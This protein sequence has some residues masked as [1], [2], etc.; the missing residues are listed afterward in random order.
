MN[1][2]NVFDEARRLGSPEERA[3]YL[4]DACADDKDQRR[5]IEALL[6]ADGRTD[7][8]LDE[9]ILADPTE[10]FKTSMKQPGQNIG[11]YK[12]LQQIGE[13]GFGVVYLAEQQEPVRRRV[14]LKVIK[15]GMDSRQVIA[16]FE[17]E[18]QAL[19]LMDHPN[20]A[21]VLDAGMTDSGRPYF[22]M[23]LVKGL[24]ITKFCDDQELS[25]SER[26]ELFVPVC[27]A[28]QHAHQK[29]VIH[30]DIKPSNVLVGV[31]DGQPVPKVIDFGVAKAIQHQLTEKTVFTKYGQVVGTLEYMSP[32]QAEFNQLDIDTRSDV[33][34]LGAVLY[35]L[36]TGSTPLDRSQLQKAAFD[37][38]LRI[39]REEEPLRPS[40]R[41]SSLESLPAI[42][43][44]RKIEPAKLTR[45]VRG[46][47]DWIVMKSL[48]KERS[49]RYPTASALADDIHRHLQGDP[50]TAAAPSTRYR[51]EK[52][53]N[54]HRTALS[55]AAS[56]L[57]LLIVGIAATASLAVM[58]SRLSRSEH[59]QRTLA[60][61]ETKRANTASEQ[62]DYARKEAES[63]AYLASM[64]LAGASWRQGDVARL[65]RILAK[66]EG[67]EKRGLE[68]NYWQGQ[69]HQH[70][71][72]LHPGIGP[73]AGVK[74]ISGGQE[75]AIHDTRRRFFLD[76][77]TGKIRA[78]YGKNW[79]M[80]P[81]G[82]WVMSPTAL[83]DTTTG[84]RSPLPFR[85]PDGESTHL[86]GVF[87]ADGGRF[88]LHSQNE[89]VVW[90]MKSGSRF[91]AE[92][93]STPACF[94]PDGKMIAF[95]T[96]GKDG[97]ITVRRTEDGHVIA[98]LAE[99]TGRFRGFSGDSRLVFQE[100]GEIRLLGV[101][102]S[103]TVDVIRTPGPARGISSSPDGKYIAAILGETILIYDSETH[104]EVSRYRGHQARVNGLAFT[105]DGRQLISVSYDGTVKFWPVEGRNFV[106]VGPSNL[107]PKVPSLAADGSR[108]LVGVGDDRHLID[109]ASRKTLN[110][111][112]NVSA[113]TLSG[114]G[115]RVVYVKNV[116][117]RS[118][119]IF[120]ADDNGT[121][122]REFPYEESI[123]VIVSSTHAERAFILTPTKFC[124]FDTNSGKTILSV[125]V[126]SS[127][128]VFGAGFCLNKD[129]MHVGVE[130][131]IQILSPSTGALI[132]TI[133]CPWNVMQAV[134][135]SELSQNGKQL[136]VAYEYRVP[137]SF[138]YG[139]AI[140]DVATGKRIQTIDG[141]AEGILY[142]SFSPDG[143]R[144]IS[145]SDITG[146]IRL[147]DVEAGFELATIAEELGDSVR[148]M[149]V[150]A[151]GQRI[152]ACGPGGVWVRDIATNNQVALW[153][154]SE[155]TSE[156]ADNDWWGQV[157]AIQDWL[158]L[159][160]I[161][162]PAKSPPQEKVD[163]ELVSG[164]AELRPKAGEVVSIGG[165]D[166]VWQDVAT[167]FWR[168]DFESV[169]ASRRDHVAA[170]AVC[171]VH[172]DQS[173]EDVRLLIGVDNYAKVYLNEE[174]VYETHNYDFVRPGKAEV[175]VN[176]RSGENVL[177]MRV[178]DL[179][180]QWGA[181]VQLRSKDNKPLTGVRTSTQP[182]TPHR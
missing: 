8:L 97:Q 87:S 154:A 175:M 24:P 77:R 98:N 90:D 171:Y 116:D 114:D 142:A 50:V 108:L 156:Q 47:L 69:L 17:A 56:V 169:L 117:G 100:G 132:R 155:K 170:Y 80:S 37:E 164:E 137:R 103:S 144:I 78:L 61:Q 119:Q 63:R 74:V 146:R 123:Q 140:F 27:N 71:R 88:A 79:P 153:Q 7:S 22:V 36:L 68:W 26:L 112:A 134:G 111:F 1:D 46:E 28:I 48:E 84:D 14:A 49:R 66:T 59:A 138:L 33:Y 143:R 52:F 45:F 101:S 126:D 15:P 23:E 31:Y 18:R 167:G 62:A 2:D 91:S 35:E 19:A 5:R 64:A 145:H 30:R 53:V 125:P 81:D 60:E 178:G 110:V 136:V 148:E 182:L 179:T 57:A 76:I 4:D 34:S 82:R 65:K 41:L 147:W 122:I 3:A 181:S 109:I 6:D 128:R 9:P 43:A 11:P 149:T 75:L 38:M 141:L 118:S 113:A 21:K 159:A 44:K 58:Y 94:S 152:V 89:L 83:I 95:G 29:G 173:N 160:P 131:E 135:W 180:D 174:P 107:Y 25:P 105:S 121:T 162:V 32:E 20:I 151:N 129:V 16:R 139:M 161:P 104:Q 99:E 67:S 96:P 92:R 106:P 54:K 165:S 85:I 55:V 176:L 163:M 13:G 157:G 166:F 120:I 124:I 102:D 133:P 10:D 72:E 177:V 73:I 127:Q 12:L 42:S 70:L 158:V 39:I 93:S 115:N 130:E 86:A 150:S 51:V 172:S 40:V 168:I